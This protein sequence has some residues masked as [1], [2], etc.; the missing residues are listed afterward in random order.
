[1]LLIIVAVGLAGY[2][3]WRLFTA[4]VG[5][6]NPDERKLHRRAAAFASGL[7]YAGLCYTA[8]RIL[9]GAGTSGASSNPKHETAGVLGWPGGPELVAIAGGV[10][11]GVRDRAGLHRHLAQ[12]R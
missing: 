10:L 2:A 12:L 4:V 1:M 6:G 7:V 8:L 3:V 11:A 9:V 5:S